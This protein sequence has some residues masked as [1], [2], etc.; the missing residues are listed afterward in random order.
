MTTVEW[1]VINGEA[2]FNALRAAYEGEPLGLLYI[3]TGDDDDR[4]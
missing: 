1:W 3:E 2:L 4:P